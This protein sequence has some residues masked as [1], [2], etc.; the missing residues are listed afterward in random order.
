MLLCCVVLCRCSGT[1]RLRLS[2]KHFYG[3][4]NTAIYLCMRR[5]VQKMQLI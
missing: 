5:D 3:T 2:W 4:I 1:F